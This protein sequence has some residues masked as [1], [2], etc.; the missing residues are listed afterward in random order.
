MT[1]KRYLFGKQFPKHDA[2][3]IDVKLGT[4]VKVDVS[5]VLRWNVRHGATL[6]PTVSPRGGVLAPLGQTKVTDLR[7]YRRTSLASVM[8]CCSLGITANMFDKE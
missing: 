4:A 8:H 7:Q 6:R 2:E 1:S 3:A 5:P